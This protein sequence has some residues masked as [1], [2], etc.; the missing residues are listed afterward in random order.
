MTTTS[1]LATTAATEPRKRVKLWLAI[2]GLLFGLILGAVLLLATGVWR[3]RPPQLHGFVM[4]SPHPV[5]NFTLMG[6][7]GKAIS[8]RDFRGQVVLLY[9]GY[10]YCPDVCPATLVELKQAV[11]ALDKDAAEVQMIMVSVD[12]E[13]D[14]PESLQEYVSYFHPSF[15][16]LTGT[17]SEVL[18]AATPLG[19]FFEKSEGTAATGYLIDH[20]ARVF[21]IDRKGEYWLSFPFEMDREQMQADLENVL[22]QR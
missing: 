2:G 18:A 17:E 16:G 3:L 8:L 9:F 19:V 20:T 22:R 21:V 14:T 12:P 10:T 7:E 11:Q 1:E 5:A 15:I 13:R 4:Q 6:A